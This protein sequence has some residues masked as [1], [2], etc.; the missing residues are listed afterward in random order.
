LLRTSG[1]SGHGSGTPL[2]EA[3]SQ[4][5]DRLAFLFDSLGMLYKA[6]LIQ[7]TE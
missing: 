6:P 3:I 1:N 7:T 2:K 4:Q 5:V